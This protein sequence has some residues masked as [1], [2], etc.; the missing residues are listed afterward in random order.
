MKPHP[1]LIFLVI[2]LLLVPV[3]FFYQW[4]QRVMRPR[5]S[6]GRLFL[7]IFSNFVLVIVYTVLVVGL[8]VRL[9]PLHR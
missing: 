9:F 6:A 8:I 1:L 4:L 3:Y 7:F 2:L 5:E